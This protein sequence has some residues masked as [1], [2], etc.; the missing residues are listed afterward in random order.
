MLK[1]LEKSKKSPNFFFYEIDITNKEKIQPFF[2]NVDWVFHLAAKADIVPSI[3]NPR[4]YFETNV[5]GTFN[6]LEAAKNNN[7]KRFIYAA[8]SSCY[9]IAKQYP[10]PENAAICCEY[11]YAL[12]KYLGE[13]LVM[14][15]AKVYKLPSISLRFFN[16][17]LK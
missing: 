5:D 9:G 3:E 2:K 7:V 8:S 13:Q 10:T 14:H 12:T 15:F 11:P 6:V 1:N 16:V 4:I 17:Y